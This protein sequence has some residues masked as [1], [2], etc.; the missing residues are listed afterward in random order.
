MHSTQVSYYSLSQ[1]TSSDHNSDFPSHLLH[2]HLH[3]SAPYP[4]RRPT[5]PA[6]S[7]QV[8]LRHSDPV[9]SE[10]VSYRINSGPMWSEQ[11]S[12]TYNFEP[13][14]LEFI[15]SFGPVQPEFV[16]AVPSDSVQSELRPLACGTSGFRRSVT[17]TTSRTQ[18]KVPSR[19]L[20][21]TATT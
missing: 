16:Q 8:V 11:V 10:Q 17:N 15:S 2:S 6:T 14:C 4:V 9:W 1:Q 12:L 5:P 13:V 18:G 7:M 20:M 19:S 21:Q 3:L